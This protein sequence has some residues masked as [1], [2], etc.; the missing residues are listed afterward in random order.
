[1]DS[2][3]FCFICFISIVISKSVILFRVLAIVTSSMGLQYNKLVFWNIASSFIFLS[4]FIS[5][6]INVFVIV[7]CSDLDRR[8]WSVLIILAEVFLNI[9]S[10][11]C[12]M[13]ETYQ[14][15]GIFFHFF[16]LYSYISTQQL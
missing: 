8:V 4:Y 16:S 3:Y 6:M 7:V 9:I 12:S 1:M 11:I 15:I 14:T 5:N 13:M 2:M 10:T